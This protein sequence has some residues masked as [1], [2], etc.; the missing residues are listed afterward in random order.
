MVTSYESDIN[1]WEE[2]Q[3]AYRFGVLLIFPPDPVLRQVNG[4]RAQ[5]DPRS[6]A[7]CDAHI[8]LTIP[9]PRPLTETHWAELAR[10]AAGNAPIPVHYGPLMNYLPHPGVCLAIEPQTELDRL[11]I[12]LE[13]ASA[14]AGAPAR[15]HPFSAHM[16]I[17]E[18]ISVEQTEAL[19]R[20]LADVAPKGVFTC[21]AVSYAVPDADFHFTERRR[22]ALANK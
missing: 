13:S 4:L 21:S 18:F 17:A 10:L 20:Q 12:A 3:Q 9:L 15:R 16:T 5:Y 1:H 7:I 8:S 22:L 6:Q 2:W 11:R 19:M 14:F